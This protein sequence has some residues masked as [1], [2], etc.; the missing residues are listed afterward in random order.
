MCT[1]LV[2]EVIVKTIT[3]PISVQQPPDEGDWDLETVEAG[4]DE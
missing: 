1:H 2:R 4:D 3:R